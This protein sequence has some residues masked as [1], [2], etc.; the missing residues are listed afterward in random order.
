[1][2]TEGLV[3]T[4]PPVRMRTTAA[5]VGQVSAAENGHDEVVEFILLPQLAFRCW[6]SWLLSRNLSLE[7]EK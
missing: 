4:P 6:S 3:R 2:V 1:M 7:S 5:H